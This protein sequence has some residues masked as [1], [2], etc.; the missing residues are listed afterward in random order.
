TLL[1]AGSVRRRQE[2]A[3]RRAMGAGSRRLAAQLLVE[4]TILAL[5]A[6]ALGILASAWLLGGLMALAPDDLPRAA[7]V[8]LD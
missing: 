3:I 6:G 4:S 2:F 5:V 8:G 1:L 7:E